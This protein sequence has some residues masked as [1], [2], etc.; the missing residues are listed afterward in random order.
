M[1]HVKQNVRKLVK[2]TETGNVN[3]QKEWNP[4]TRNVAANQ[5]ANAKPAW[6]TVPLQA[7][8]LLG[9]IGHLVTAN[10]VQGIEKEK[11]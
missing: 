6:A 3:V 10:A 5:P 2:C 9:L 8:L 7:A 1:D 4:T 11:E